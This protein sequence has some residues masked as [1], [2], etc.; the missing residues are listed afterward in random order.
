[1]LCFVHTQQQYFNNE[2]FETIVD[3]LDNNY[4]TLDEW[5]PDHACA[6]VILS[7][8]LSS[9]LNLR[10]IQIQTVSFLAHR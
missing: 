9:N 3:K 1:M 6:R 8:F 10:Q 4:S 7:Q 5:Q 2:N